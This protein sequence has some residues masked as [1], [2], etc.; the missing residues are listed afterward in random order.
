M[1]ILVQTYATVDRSHWSTVKL[2]MTRLIPLLIAFICFAACKKDKDKTDSTLVG[3]WLQTAQY[4]EGPQT[5]SCWKSVTSDM[6]AFKVEF[7]ENGNFSMTP[8]MHF[9]ALY[10][11]GTYSVAGDSIIWTNG[12][13]G[14]DPR[15]TVSHYF[16][17]EDNNTLLIK[18]NHIPNYYYEMKFKRVSRF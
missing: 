6:A 8:P 15:P 2:Y 9:S 16:K 7:E 17:L 5:C 4:A 3:K 14:P 18:Y 11:P 10:C 12:L 1:I 13:C